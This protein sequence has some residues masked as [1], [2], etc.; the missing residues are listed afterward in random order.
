MYHVMIVDDELYARTR[1]KVDLHLEQDG[2]LVDQ[3][4]SSGQEA[5]KRMCAQ[6]PDIL[7]MDM[8]MPGMDGV[9]LLKRVKRLYPD[10]P[11]IAL[12]GYEDFAYV[13]SS[14]K[15]GAVDYLLKHDLN[16]EVVLEALQK[17]A[18]QIRQSCQKEKDSRAEAGRVTVAAG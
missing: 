11:A 2:F 13:R 16:R 5:L 14:L 9:E 7:M 6:R 17:C 3:E 1:V 10:L 4:A 15:L 12:S 8:R 18:E